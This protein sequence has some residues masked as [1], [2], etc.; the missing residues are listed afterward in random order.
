[1]NQSKCPRCDQPL[2]YVQR[3]MEYH[4]F[5]LSHDAVD[6]PE[7]EL[8]ALEE[9]I[10]DDDYTPYILCEKCEISFNL[11][12]EQTGIGAV[13]KKQ[14]QV[15]AESAK[16]IFLKLTLILTREEWVELV[17]SLTTK[18]EFVSH[19]TD[20]LGQQKWLATLYRIYGKI[21]KMVEDNGVE[22]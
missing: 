14:A 7:A 2:R 15:T 4:S 8:I 19:L 16:E 11:K 17:H 3:V 10:P 20:Y 22:C 18:I 12:L 5:H 6:K 9:S 21:Q 1:M 13:G